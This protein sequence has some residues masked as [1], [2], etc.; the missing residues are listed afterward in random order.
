MQ[1]T[2]PVV[3]IA[4]PGTGGRKIRAISGVIGSLTLALTAS[5]FFSVQAHAFAKAPTPV[6][7][8][9]ALTAPAEGE[10]APES[11]AG[12]PR[13]D[14]YH[15]GYQYGADSAGRIVENVAAKTVG[16]E[17]CGAIGSMEN[18]L[19]NVVRAIRPPRSSQSPATG[20]DE[21]VRGYYRGYY[22]RV[23]EGIRASR[24][25]CSAVQFETGIVPGRLSGAFLCSSAELSLDWVLGGG[26]EMESVYEGW[27]GGQGDLSRECESHVEVE[28]VNC[29]LG[30][31]V[32]SIRLEITASC[33]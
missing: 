5:T 19:V 23:R 30:G 4:P 12:V 27:S 9:P 16:R 20:E 28:L 8:E 11:H 17:G 18:A 7:P 3:A 25:G 26:I 24:E 1:N 31:M 22:D 29:S 15:E 2:Q 33:R 14:R 32:D 6:V 10:A 21:F 13:S